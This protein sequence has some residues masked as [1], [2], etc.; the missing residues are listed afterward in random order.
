M[1]RGNKK[2]KLS[3]EDAIAMRGYWTEA[4]KQHIG[5][6]VHADA[7]IFHN[8]HTKSCQ[9][10]EWRPSHLCDRVCVKCFPLPGGPTWDHEAVMIRLTTKEG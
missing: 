8:P 6:L 4:P 7:T 9:C 1:A 5:D 10:V 2:N 3:P